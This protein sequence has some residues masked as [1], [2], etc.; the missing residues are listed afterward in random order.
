MAWT[1]HARPLLEGMPS[2]RRVLAEVAFVLV[3]TFAGD[4]PAPWAAAFALLVAGFAIVRPW[5]AAGTLARAG[6]TLALVVT[7]VMPVVLAEAM[8]GAMVKSR[9]IGVAI[10]AVQ[11]G[12]DDPAV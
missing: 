9:R 10:S 6:A 7:I 5:R 8:H 11:P 1:D 3:V 2:R 12:P 4:L